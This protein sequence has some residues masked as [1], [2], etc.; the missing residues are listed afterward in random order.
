MVYFLYVCINV[1]SMAAGI[2]SLMPPPNTA[3]QHSHMSK[4]HHTPKL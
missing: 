4:S 3:S 2:L 1:C